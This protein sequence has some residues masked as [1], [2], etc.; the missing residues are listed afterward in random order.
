MASSTAVRVVAPAIALVMAAGAAIRVHRIGD[1][2][3]RATWRDRFSTS[4]YGAGR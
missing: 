4:A 3:A 2:G 1:S